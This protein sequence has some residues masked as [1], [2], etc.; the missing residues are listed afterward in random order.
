METLLFHAE[1][2]KDTDGLRPLDQ[3]INEISSLWVRRIP[4]IE[5]NT[6]MPA[7]EWSK[8]VKESASN[9]SIIPW[10]ELSLWWVSPWHIM[11]IFDST[12]ELEDFNNIFYEKYFIEETKWL[13]PPISTFQPS[14]LKNPND[15]IIWLKKIEEM[16]QDEKYK[17]TI[18]P[19]ESRA[20]VMHK[21]IHNRES[22]KIKKL[23]IVSIP[24]PVLWSDNSLPSKKINALKMSGLTTYWWIT[25][26][27]N[28][29][30]RL[31]A[32][33]KILKEKYPNE[34]VFL[35]EVWWYSM[36][37][38]ATN[39]SQKIYDKY[40]KQLGVFPVIW[41]D[42]HFPVYPM[43]WFQIPNWASL[44][45][46]FLTVNW[47]D[48]WSF[49]EIFIKVHW[50]NTKK[51]RTTILSILFWIRWWFDPLCNEFPNLANKNQISKT[52]ESLQKSSRRKLFWFIAQKTEWLY[53]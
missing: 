3:Y 43:Q 50:V 4:V 22:W 34:A 6:L 39:L 8:I 37:K 30:E 11:F 12:E 47:K 5:H 28:S 18:F 45:D 42:C 33:I 15:T 36:P 41:D 44:R 38:N 26:D 35:F 14:R 52:I 32:M 19:W 25:Q 21:L 7:L 40:F 27:I 24:H 13:L 23:P 31:Q 51:I 1:H 17:Y 2:V 20:E 46:Y 10:I 16:K 9:T 53:L 49:Q 48:F 29:T